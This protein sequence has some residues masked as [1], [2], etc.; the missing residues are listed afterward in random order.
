MPSKFTAILAIAAVLPALSNALEPRHASSLRATADTE[1][2][3]QWVLNWDSVTLHDAAT[4][5]FIGRFAL[6]GAAQSSSRDLCPP[7]I[8]AGARGVAY[9]S[10]NVQPVLWRVHATTG[11]VE[12]LEMEIDSDRAKDFGFTGLDLSADGTTLYAMS[13]TDGATWRL[14]PVTRKAFKTGP[15][16]RVDRDCGR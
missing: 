16:A 6:E 8:V 15:K 1:G 3:H 13:S 5:R 12:R 2:V 14:D 11:H 10:S 9:V 7:G 4:S